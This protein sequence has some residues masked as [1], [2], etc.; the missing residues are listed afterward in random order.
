MSARMGVI[1]V[2]LCVLFGFTAIFG[3]FA[4]GPIARAADPGPPPIPPLLQVNNL[5][6]IGQ[7]PDIY[8]RDGTYSALVN[9]RSV[10]TFGDTPLAVPGQSGD[11][12]VDNSL[13]WT[14]DLDASDGITLEHDHLDKTGAPAE[15]L[16]YTSAER[17]YNYLHDDDHCRAI[18]C[19]AEYA[20]WAGHI[21][22]DPTRNRVLLFYS[23]IWRKTGQPDWTYIGSGI[24]VKEGSGPITRPIQNPGSP[25][26]TLMW[27]DAAG[28]VGLDGGY[29]IE[30]ALLYAYGCKAG[31]LVMDCQ[32]GRVPLAE[33]L[34][35]TQWRYYAGD[36]VWS[37]NQSDAVIIFNGG[38]AGQTVFYVPYLGMYMAVYSGV[39]SDDVFYRVAW[40]PWG[41][42]SEEAFL[43]T[44]L[45][46]WEGNFSYAGRAHPEFA[47]QDGRV[48]YIT[49]VHTT[50]FLRFDLPLMQV[51]FGD[52]QHPNH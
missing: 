51:V 28:E 38:A 39:F 4:S 1:S 24:A 18:P 41:P 12:W 48:Q 37:A 19:G 31:F 13:S 46:G 29:V 6:V 5:G 40:T 32:V 10:W 11:H 50:G 16:P 44:A 45:P 30:G 52:P 49:Y 15:F 14:N 9:G 8:G 47:E 3:R 36:G 7:N 27:T 33:A 17:R 25:N 34:D 43:F 20:L 26:P 35:K 21:V 22:P 23:E 42:W 2:G